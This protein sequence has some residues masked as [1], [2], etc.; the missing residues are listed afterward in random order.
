MSLA[1]SPTLK[2]GEPFPRGSDIADD[3]SFD[4]STHHAAMETDCDPNMDNQ[5]SAKVK[6]RSLFGFGKKKDG[7][8]SLTTASDAVPALPVPSQT[9]KPSPTTPKITASPPRLHTGE[10]FVFVHPSSPAR[11]ISSSPR[12]SS[13]AGS[14]IFER[15]VQDS[16]VLKPNSP[17]IPTHI[18]TE[19]YI[20]PVLDDASEAITNEKLDPDAVEIVTHTSHQPASVTVT[21]TPGGLTSPYDQMASEWAAELASFADRVGLSPDTASNYGSL[22][23]TDVRRLSFI[24]FADVVQAEHG[25]QAG[26]T[27]SRDSLHTVGLTSLPSATLNRSPSPIR[28]PV[29]SQ[30]QGTS[31]PTSNPGSMK[32]VEMSPTRKPF[33]SPKPG[34]QNMAATG[35]D[36]NIE[37]MRQALRRTGNTDLSSFRSNP[38][39]PTDGPGSR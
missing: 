3:G 14:Q 31:P 22:D 33:G 38:A 13:P 32:G 7:S 23:S 8:T 34:Q 18:Q 10:H 20:P 35:G 25:N 1:E 16:T 19:N 6:K 30:G 4:D 17:A 9:S 21:G 15:D 11:A 36:L 39:S 37:T 28:S 12:V 24:S 27:G 26:G 29:S 5:K 2:R